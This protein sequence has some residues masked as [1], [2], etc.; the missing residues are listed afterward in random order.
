MGVCRQGSTYS[1]SRGVSP[2]RWYQVDNIGR[3]T[4]FTVG[5][6]GVSDS[7]RPCIAGVRPR[8][9]PTRPSGP[10]PEGE[11]GVSRFTD[12]LGNVGLTAE[13]EAAI[14]EFLKTLANGYVLP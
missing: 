1:R 7:Q 14:V 10:L 5:T 8:T 12:E 3:L 2:R 4:T 11:P 9:F 13:E 6:M